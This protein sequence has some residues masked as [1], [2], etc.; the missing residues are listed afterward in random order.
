MIVSEFKRAA[1]GRRG[2]SADTASKLMAGDT[3]LWGRARSFG[4]LLAEAP[5]EIRW[6]GSSEG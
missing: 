2:E 1:D 5:G 6:T 4:D 3:L